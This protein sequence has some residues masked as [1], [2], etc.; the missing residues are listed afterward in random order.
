MKN[1]WV[2]IPPFD[3]VATRRPIVAVL[4][5]INRFSLIMDTIHDREDNYGKRE[6]DR[7]FLSELRT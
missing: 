1:L 3:V 7:I 4:L 2:R 5:H 6:K